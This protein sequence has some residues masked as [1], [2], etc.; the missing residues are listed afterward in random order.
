MRGAG[1]TGG[2]LGATIRSG[3]IRWSPA[4][5]WASAIARAGQARAARTAAS[6]CSSETTAWYASWPSPRSEKI[7]GASH[8][9]MLDKPAE[10]NRLLLA[11]LEREI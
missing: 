9:M 7:S 8:W 5:P 4:P 3:M 10:L 6:I 2:S 1:L 11:F